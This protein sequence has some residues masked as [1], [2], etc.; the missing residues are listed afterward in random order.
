MSLDAGKM[1]MLAGKSLIFF[2]TAEFT[3]KIGLQATH[4]YLVNKTRFK[5]VME[6]FQKVFVD[7][8]SRF[9]C[10]FFP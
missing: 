10:G 5:V 9:E 4:Y 1:G 7:D 8:W 6:F 2:I 3:R